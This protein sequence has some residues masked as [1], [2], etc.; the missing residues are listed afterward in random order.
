M[1]LFASPI[2]Q[3]HVRMEKAIPLPMPVPSSSRRGAVTC[4]DTLYFRSRCLI[5]WPLSCVFVPA[6]NRSTVRST[7][8]SGIIPRDCTHRSMSP[9]LAPRMTSLGVPPADRTEPSVPGPRSVPFLS[10][11]RCEMLSIPHPHRTVFFSLVC[12]IQP[13]LDIKSYGTPFKVAG[14][15][16][17]LDWPLS[18]VRFFSKMRY[19]SSR[20]RGF[21]LAGR[22]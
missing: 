3:F 1:G 21:A 2:R 7:P 5:C 9:G 8:Y 10:H 11:A 12:W 6:T 17:I 22:S 4:R 20:A 14:Q 15:Q 16:S 19:D 18:P 13:I